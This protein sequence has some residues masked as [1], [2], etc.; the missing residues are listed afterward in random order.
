MSKLSQVC[1]K[2]SKKTYF[3]AFFLKNINIK[4][5]INNIVHGAAQ[6]RRGRGDSIFGENSCH[7]MV[8]IRWISTEFSDFRKINKYSSGALYGGGGNAIW[9]TGYMADSGFFGW[10]MDFF[11]KNLIFSEKIAQ[12]RKKIVKKRPKI[13][14]IV[15]HIRSPPYSRS[16]I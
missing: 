8:K 14:K 4:F 11:R 13:A 10:K 9:R 16:A 7:Q 2:T 6:P 1:R 12:N 3:W 15:R 5:R